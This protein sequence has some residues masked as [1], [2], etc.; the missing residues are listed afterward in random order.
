[1][2]TGFSVSHLKERRQTQREQRTRRRRSKTR[3]DAPLSL[4]PQR[5]LCHRRSTREG[6]TVGLQA[7]ASRLPATNC[8]VD[9]YVDP[10]KAEPITPYIT[11]NTDHR[12][13]GDAH[14]CAVCRC[15]VLEGLLGVVEAGSAVQSELSALGGATQRAVLA[16]LARRVTHA[17]LRD[18][19][20]GVW[21]AFCVAAAEKN[22]SGVVSSVVSVVRQWQARE[23]GIR[24]QI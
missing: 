7:S 20:V 3:I 12:G 15:V 11:R 13:P 23:T 6:A 4:L 5:Q 14:D 1:M 10:P 24:C 17:T 18:N 22:G 21:A 16:V 19:G 2:S 9:T 8:L